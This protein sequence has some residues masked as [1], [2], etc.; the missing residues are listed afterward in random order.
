MRN[1]DLVELSIDEAF[2]DQVFLK[3]LNGTS[4]VVVDA[5]FCRQVV[6]ISGLIALCRSG[7]T[8]PLTPTMATVAAKPT[9]LRPLSKYELMR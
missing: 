8:I 2:S 5:L 6:I 9:A 1:S 4:S 7:T 3:R